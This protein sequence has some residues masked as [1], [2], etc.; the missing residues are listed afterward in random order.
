MTTAGAQTPVKEIRPEK[1]LIKGP[2][3]GERV[4][5]KTYSGDWPMYRYDM[6]RSGYSK[7]KVPVKL[8]ETWKISITKGKKITPPVTA[9]GKVFL[10][11]VDQHTL[12]AV[13]AIT[14]KKSW[15]FQAGGRIDSAPTIYKGR[16][17]F[18]SAD[19]SLYCLRASDGELIWR[20]FAAPD[21]RQMISRGQVESA[22]P[23][24]GSVLI[25]KDTIYCLAGRSIFLDTGMR[26]YRIDPETGKMI[27]RHVMN[28]IFPA[29]GKDMQLFNQGLK[30]V[31]ANSDLLTSTGDAI[32]MK[33][34]KI[35]L[36]GERVFGGKE[37]EATYNVGIQEPE[38]THL[39][40][41]PGFLD[42]DWHHRS[43]WL[44]GQSAGSGW[45]NWMKP[46]RYV[47]AGRILVVK[48]GSIVFGYGREPAFFAQ[49]HV[50]EY[51]L[52][53][54]PGKK[55]DRDQWKEVFQYQKTEEERIKHHGLEKEQGP[56]NKQTERGQVSLAQT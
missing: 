13:D 15:I 24:H 26:L 34:Q 37:K 8:K 27:S 43:Y 17:I 6:S 48:D 56:G 9:E 7:T 32:Y 52:F 12:H 42:T 18:G 1:R 53:S 3:F 54:A 10:A 49:S 41:G 51:Q 36:K 14:G 22:W 16:V 23:V 40:S 44:F 25:V 46:G 11:A 31:P 50:L 39:F 29:T 45:G 35:S 20:F 21:K 28:E 47:P 5:S 30:M 33:A 2:A 55:Y 4:S 19:G 38:E